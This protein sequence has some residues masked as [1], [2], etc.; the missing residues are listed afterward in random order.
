MMK[1]FLAGI[2]AVGMVATM[3]SGCG[4]DGTDKKS[5]GGTGK[6][7]VANGKELDGGKS[8]T[9]RFATQTMTNAP[10]LVSIL[11]QFEKDYPN[12]K[13]EIEESPGNDLITKINTDIMG[14]N[15]PDLFTFWRPEAKW[16]VDKFIEKG[17]LADLTELVNTDPF[18]ENLFPEYAWNTSTVNG[19]VYCIPRMN[20]YVEFLVNKDVFE[21]YD[22][23]L[24]T[25]W[26]ALVNACEQLKA[27]GIIPW[28]VDT[29]EG[30]DDSSRIF[31][32]II[33]R[34]VGNAKGLELL[35]GAESF[36]DAEV[37]RALDYFLEVASGNAPED[38]AILD[39]NQ[40][41]TKYLNTGK[42]GMVIGNCVQ[43]NINLTDEI[44]ESLVAMNLPLTPDAVIDAPS[45]EQDLSNLVYI[46]SKAYNDPDKKD[47]VIELMKRMVSPEAAK[48]YLEEERMVVPHL[49][50]EV[51]PAA[52][53]A[54]QIEAAEIAENSA[55][56]KWLLSFAKPGPV[57]NFRIVINEAWIGKYAS[58][59]EL[60]KALDEAL[61]QK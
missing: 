38:A 17:A 60:A 49:N 28:C 50:L 47:Y 5:G 41:I 22:I 24:P 12:V 14:D 32:A 48:R 2:L 42:A 35:K 34:V 56:D 55:S 21:Q 4:S 29:K 8:V 25:D 44:L 6:T 30:L 36:Q 16:N 52:V 27:N 9:I 37:I 45:L 51:D 59:K 61:Y 57:D 31:N 11:D 20:F 19:S 3:L 7:V 58:G 33:N 46:S 39:F 43:I 13:L 23:P 53:P 10:V 1:K 15:A 26:D 54:V 40:A 18:F